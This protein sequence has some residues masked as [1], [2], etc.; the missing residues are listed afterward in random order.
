M[1]ALA[2]DGAPGPSRVATFRAED[3]MPERFRAAGL[4]AAGLVTSESARA[5]GLSGAPAAEGTLV[6]SEVLLRAGVGT[7]VT[8]E[9][10]WAYA[11][12]GTDFRVA[13]PFDVG[14]DVGYA[15]TWSRDTSGITQQRLSFGAGPGIALPLVPRRLELRAR[16]EGELQQLRADVTQPSTGRQDASGRTLVGLAGEVDLDI[17]LGAGLELFLG[18]RVA[19][20]GSATSVRV[21][22]VP[23]ETIGSWLE[24][25]IVGL[26]VRLP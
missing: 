25:A 18:D 17:P 12:F 4:I 5:D 1:E 23:V 9:R 22:N 13:G 6:A 11:Q 10:S 7:G 3:P 19:G 16:I 14:L 21:Q 24:V 8:D 20:W 26:N 2:A 15:R